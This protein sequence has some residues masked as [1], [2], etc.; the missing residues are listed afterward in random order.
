LFGA[1]PKTPLM[2]ELQ[3]TKEYLGFATHLAY[4]GTLFE[5]VLAADTHAAGR[6]STVARVVD[7]R[8]HGTRLTGIAGVANVG[9]DRTWSGSHFDQANWYAF[10]RLAWNPEQHARA[11]AEEWVRMT[12]SNAPELV[13]PTVEMMMASRDTVVDYMTPLGLHHLMGSGHHYGP[14]PW[15]DDLARPDWNPVYYHRADAAGLGFDRTPSGSG[16]VTRYA[17]A[18]ARTFGDPGK[19]PEEL[20]LW[21]HHVPWDRRM[22]SGRT[23]WE[24]LV[25]RY[26]RGADA[27]AAMQGRWD[28]LAPYVDAERHAAVAAFLGVQAR[29]ARWWRDACVAYFQTFAQRPLPAGFTP[30]EHSLDVY[31]A[32]D[33]PFVPGH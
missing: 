12:F 10:G 22:A 16:A 15:V 24:E 21:F 3:I 8:L 26:T 33:F 14:A 9:S 2:L 7:G 1:M 4:L 28:A 23:L 29:E 27:V 11:L 30:P 6:G 17:P 31:R 20:L 18:V 13:T 19:V 5:E 32:L 25:V